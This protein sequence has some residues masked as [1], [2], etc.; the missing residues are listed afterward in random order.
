MRI[1]G[2]V[3]ALRARKVQ[4]RRKTTEEKCCNTSSHFTRI[5]TVGLDTS[6]RGL[7]GVFLCR[8]CLLAAHA[9]DTAGGI[10]G[11]H[12]DHVR[13]TVLQIADEVAQNAGSTLG[14]TEKK[15]CRKPPPLRISLPTLQSYH[16]WMTAACC[17]ALNPTH[18]PT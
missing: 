2:A 13:G 6:G 10:R 3:S 12:K 4:V 15:N 9:P 14:L 18:K 7:F 11:R 5:S 17:S 1:L 8:A 16:F